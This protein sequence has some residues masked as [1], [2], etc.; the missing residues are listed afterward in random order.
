M[1]IRRA[2]S[3]DRA[4]VLGL[5]DEMSAFFKATDVPS[6]V[7][8]KIYDEVI[9]RRDT[10]IFVAEENGK[11]LGVA[12]FYLLPNL[13]HGWHRGHIED[14][15]VAETARGKGVGTKIFDAIKNYC[16]NNNIKVIKLDSAI[17]LEDAHKFY[18][19]NGGKF[20]E[21]MFRFDI[22]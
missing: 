12:T 5:L 8:N 13:R 15:Y 7:G 19:K 20:K 17:E 18:E 22:D 1:N 9:S 11:L 14:F 10:K 6:K 2:T 4:K 21:Q 16:K 3:K